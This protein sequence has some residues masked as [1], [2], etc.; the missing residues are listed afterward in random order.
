MRLCLILCLFL[1]GCTFI[2]HTQITA[3]ANGVKAKVY[4][5]VNKGTVLIDCTTIIC[6]L[7]RC[8]K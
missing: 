6:V 2:R 4:G 3:G 7:K 8:P 5:E 1:S